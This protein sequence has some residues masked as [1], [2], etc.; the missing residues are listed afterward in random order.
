MNSPFQSPEVRVVEA[1]AGSGKTSALSKRY[2]QLLLFTAQRTPLALKNILAITFTNKAA[3]EMKSRILDTLKGLA[4]GTLPSVQAQAILTPLDLKPAEVAK[5]AAGLME[6]IIRHYHFFQVQTIDS[7]MNALLAG[8]AFKI[9]LSAR[10][11]IERNSEDYLQLSLDELIDQANIQPKVKVLFE[12]FVHQYL[13]LEN[14]G[15]WFP[16]QD[17][18]A[19]L[20]ALFNQYN[21][22]QKPFVRFPL[23]GTSII[24][25]KKDFLKLAA[26]LKDILPLGM[27]K[28]FAGSLENFLRKHPQGFDMDDV[29]LYFARPSPPLKAGLVLP[30]EVDR[31]WQKMRRLLH[32]ICLQE[33]YGVFNPYVDLFEAVMVNLGRLQTKEDVLFLQQLNKK[34]RELFD[35]ELMTV[36]ELYYR[37]A[38]RFQHY[39]MDEFQDTSQAQWQNLQLMVEEALSSGGTL[40]YVGDKK[41]AI[42]SFRGGH[43]SLFDELQQAFAH[44]NVVHETLSYNFRSH[45]AIVEFN[46]RIFSVEHL[47]SFMMAVQAQDNWKDKEI[48]FGPQDWQWLEGVFGSAQQ[49]ASPQ[50]NDGAVRVELI[51]GRKKAER[52]ETTRQKVLAAVKNARQRF[53]Y[54]DIAI[55]TRNNAQVQRV[56]G[57][58]VQEGIHAQSERTSDVKNHPV[59][60]ELVSFLMFLQTPVDNTAFAAFLLGQVFPKTSGLSSQELQDFLFTCRIQRTKEETS[61]Y[62]L[63]R[64]AYPQVWRKYFE[65]FF[66]QAGVYP[67]YE[68]AVSACSRLQV[69]EFFP[70][71][72]GFVMHFLELIKRREEEGCD[73]ET[74][75]QYFE[76]LQDE[77][78]FVPM[79]PQDAV[80]VLTVHKAKGLEFPVVIIPFLEMAVRT[81]T[82][83]KSGGPS[84][85]C[86][87]P[88]SG[89][90]GLHL[91]RLK[92]SYTCFCEPLRERYCREYKG[93]FFA[94][95]N[96]VYVALT[97]AICEMHIFI[98]ER[99]SSSV[100]L[101]PLLVPPP[102]FSAGEFS[103]PA[104]VSTVVNA[105]FLSPTQHQ[106]WIK[107][108]T[109]EFLFESVVQAQARRRGEVLHF[110]LSKLSNL[111]GADVQ[112]AIDAAIG[113]AQPQFEPGHD[114]PLQQRQLQALMAHSSWQK[115]FHLPPEAKVFCELE[116]VNHF[117]DTRRIDRLVVFPQEAWVIDF[118]TSR[119]DETGH[120]V[121]ID[122]YIALVKKFYPRHK[123]TGVL[124][125]T[126]DI[127]HE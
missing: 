17:L 104:A 50:R 78:R 105:R 109:E 18:L 101:V 76:A 71:A 70:D 12:T 16:K 79:P 91:L 90:E 40:F 68:L 19:V 95:L 85:I 123:V 122:E 93:A 39:L 25:D 60:Q 37:L 113:L 126:D 54:G 26:Q 34:T 46:N 106:E 20:C 81:G 108:L 8:C 102:M 97:R 64:Q 44:Y 58:L 32:N 115:F 52:M 30:G 99:A 59:I 6:D 73:T 28:R 22:Y 31:L 65:E 72:Q 117:G 114:W 38:T 29:S 10:F 121:Q 75:L 56:T 55:L 74:F 57:W 9:H 94:E 1:S 24:E 69:I 124:L 53:G 96:N 14:R 45:K 100:N 83:D 11:K 23:S 5:L 89:E 77:G 43:S 48:C 107:Q 61:F 49:I 66:N 2:V 84:F 51:A 80:K 87:P 112:Q 82:S 103:S 7:F 42:Y 36:E 62:A 4:L 92:E 118:K 41:Q 125:Y 119:L 63:F 120:Q 67:L 86:D 88:Q 15:S 116:L 98:P 33:A 127:A 3:G 111:T 13:F 27:D 35:D 47:R 110:C 21:T